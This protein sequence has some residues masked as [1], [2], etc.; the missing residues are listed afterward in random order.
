MGPVAT[1]ERTAYHH[2]DLRGALLD[3]A[4]Q[5]IESE[6]L[7]GLSLRA[8][9]RK[10]GVSHA[11]PYHHFADRTALLAAVAEEGFQALH[12]AMLA[13]TA[14]V[15]DPRQRLRETGIGYVRFALEHPAHFRVMFSPEFRERS[16]HPGLQAAAAAAYGLLEEAIVECQRRGY[17]RP[18]D[19]D[20]MV[21]AAWALVHGIATLLL[22]GH[23]EREEGLRA[24]E[25]QVLAATALLWEGLKS[26]PAPSDPV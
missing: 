9:A 25:E 2:G 10:V 5:L 13:R 20:A 26:R 15:A 14:G 4:L 24:G 22:D 3:A 11:A 19:A 23:L 1:D 7:A 16:P 21:R 17:A 18:G 6:G 8:V 12:G